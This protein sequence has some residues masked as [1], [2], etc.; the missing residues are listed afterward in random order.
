MTV[1]IDTDI[2]LQI[3]K[4]EKMLE[5]LELLEDK[6]NKIKFIRHNRVCTI[7]ALLKTGLLKGCSIYQIFHQ[8]T[9]ENI[10]W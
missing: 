2:D 5:L 10:K 9:M 8:K 7:K 3:Q 4:L 6:S 1:N